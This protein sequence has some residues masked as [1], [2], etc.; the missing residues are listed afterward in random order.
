MKSIGEVANQFGISVHALR[1]YEKIDLIS[2]VSK[3]NGGRRIYSSKDIEKIQFIQRAKLM[4]FSLDDIRLLL[5]LDKSINSTK[6]QAQQLIKLKL[7]EVENNLKELTQL[8][9]NL[10]RMLGDCLSSQDKDCC[11]IIEELSN[12]SESK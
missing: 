10:S 5:T 9:Q 4:K 6:P 2:P 1:Y 11:P 12:E 7:G 3:T 8:K